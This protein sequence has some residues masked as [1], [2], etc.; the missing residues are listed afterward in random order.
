M[1]SIGMKSWPLILI[2]NESFTMLRAISEML[3]SE[4]R[5]K[6]ANNGRDA[7]ALAQH[8]PL[9]DLVLLDTVLPDT[10]G[11]EL[12]RKLKQSPVTQDIPII[13]I[14]AMQDES[15]EALALNLQAADYMA[16][17]FCLPVARARIRNKLMARMQ[18]SAALGGHR[19]LPPRTTESASASQQPPIG[20]GKRQTEVLALI[21]EGLTSAEIAVK[22]SIAKGTVEVHREN[23]MRKLGVHNVAG[24]LKSAIRHG[25]LEL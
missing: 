22:L 14:T 19:P 1:C 4:Y 17:P 23:I 25:L 2:V 8:N 20:L 10:S 11:L 7:M 5:I 6:I 9:P 12:C 24:L 15:Q 21:A 16:L 13:F 3:N 18:P